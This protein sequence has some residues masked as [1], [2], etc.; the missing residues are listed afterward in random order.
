MQEQDAI[1][2]HAMLVK[3][4]SKIDTT[5]KKQLSEGLDTLTMAEAKALLML[6]GNKASN[7]SSIARLLNVAVS[8]ATSV[9]DRLVKKNLAERWVSDD[10]RRQ[11][12]VD[13]T[14]KARELAAEMEKH[15][16]EGT[17]K[18]LECL[19]NSEIVFLKEILDKID[20]NVNTLD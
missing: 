9:I 3:I 1:H 14:P 15:A 20:K 10:D 17:M 6:G 11:W 7:M 8:T 5:N 18:F 13:L 19:S 12:I 4:S 16:I 2:I